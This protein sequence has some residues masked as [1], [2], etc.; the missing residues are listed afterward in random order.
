VEDDGN[1]AWTEEHIRKEER[2]LRM[3][4]GEEREVG[5]RACVHRDCGQGHGEGFQLRFSS[6]EQDMDNNVRY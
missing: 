5:H 6:T 4:E 1:G 2:L 3:R